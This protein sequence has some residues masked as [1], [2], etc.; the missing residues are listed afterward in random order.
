MNK[1]PG[2][3]TLHFHAL[4]YYKNV[5]KALY[6]YFKQADRRFVV[7]WPRY[8]FDMVLFHLLPS[9]Q[10]PV[11]YYAE[12][13]R[14][15]F[16]SCKELFFNT[17]FPSFFFIIFASPTTFASNSEEIIDRL[18]ARKRPHEANLTIEN[19]KEYYAFM[20]YMFSDS[21]FPQTA[22]F[23]ITHTAHVTPHT[24]PHLLC[25]LVF[26]IG[27]PEPVHCTYDTFIE[28]LL[29][30]YATKLCLRDIKSLI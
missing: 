11:N 30:N 28:Y 5:L 21:A 15:F 22:S 26:V 10:L 7:I 23:I 25:L 29:I 8:L 4:V 20:S 12:M 9:K 6:F 14:S 1:F 19:I 13:F 18:S 24:L 2:A 17:L 3:A 27:V 16:V